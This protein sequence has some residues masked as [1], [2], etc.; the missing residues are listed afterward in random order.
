VKK[1]DVEQ[2]IE[3]VNRYGLDIANLCDEASWK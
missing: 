1:G 3:M 2:V